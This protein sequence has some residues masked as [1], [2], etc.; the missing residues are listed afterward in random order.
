MA[1]IRDY[2]IT[3]YTTAT[4]SMVCE[5]PEHV[6]GDLLVAFTNKDTASNFT[7][8]SGWT[9]QQTQVSAGAGGGV[10]TKRAASSSETVTFALTS[11]TCNAVVI[12]VKDCNGSTE[13]DAVSSSAKSGA[14][15]SSLPL[16]GVGF[17]P[18]HDNCLVLH[19]LSCDLVT[20]ATAQPPWVNLFTGDAAANALCVSYTHQNGTAAAI[21]A[22]DHWAQVADDSRGFIIAI[23]PASSGNS[24]SPYI[25]L[26]QV[27][28]VRV[29][30]LTGTT[31][32]VDGGTYTA[33]ASIAL[34]T[35]NGKTVTG[36]SVAATADSGVNP[37]RGST[38]NAGVSSTT[39]LNHVEL[40]LS[41]S[42]DLTAGGGLLFGTY[43]FLAPRDYI[44]TGKPVNGGVYIVSGSDASNYRCWVIGGQF[45][46]TTRSD[47]RNNYLIEVATSDTIYGSAGTPSYSAMDFLAF[48]SSGYYGLPAILWNELWRI[49]GAVLAGGTSGF[50]I[51]F[52]DVIFAVN[53]GNAQLP[54]M[55]QYGA[56][57]TIWTPLKF[58]GTDPLHISCNLNTFQFPKKADEID[59]CDFHVSNNKIGIEFHGMDRGSGDV[60]T[61]S[62]TNCLFTSPSS[63]YWRFN[64]SHDADANVDFSGSSIVGASVTLRSTVT[65]DN[66]TFIDCGTF[67]QN[68]AVLTNCTFDN[69][70]V[71]S[72]APGDADNISNTSFTSAGTGHAIEIGGTA[73]DITL[74][75]LTFT[76]YAGTNGSTG[77]EA[78]YVNIA[79]GTMIISITGG[80]STPS[81]RTAGCTVTVQNAV[82][83]KVTAKDADTSAAIENARILL[84]ASTGTT[85]TITRSGSTASVSHTSHGYLTGQK[86]FISGANEQEYNG[87][88]TITVTG[89]NGYDFTVSGT[90]ATPATG[91]ITS[92]RV[93]LD[94]LTNVSGINQTT[95]F[96]YTSDL[97][98]TGRARKGTSS[99][100]YKTA[101]ISGTITSSGLDTTVFMIKDE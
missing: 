33:A 34:T 43:R 90:P 47:A 1:S 89:T 46:K 72:A 77:N 37:F 48:G 19:G 95:S 74:T 61:L 40:P 31:G 11:E 101:P 53:N 35:I 99:T 49:D 79:S 58:G 97:A 92:Y 16:T 60:D 22:P 20:A 10:Y 6:S 14:D 73:A 5:M 55:Q 45:S 86:V 70:K 69:T 15:D 24:V 59:Y 93:I 26:S 98:V 28:S 64:S 87:I 85:I 56:L 94:G 52:D 39:L 17:T 7:T 42:V 51:D 63:Y 80:G 41:S 76:G 38:R 81:I 25:P 62:F 96:N 36:V 66:V 44:D 91:T 18:S 23:R 75:G 82:T 12:S 2:A 57:A 50:P 68:S 21:T 84:Y 71:T 88:K 32:T 54:L 13:A 3:I 8:P 67:T 65:L 30:A 78:I 29:S 4:A 27:P 83:V 9:A 100:Y